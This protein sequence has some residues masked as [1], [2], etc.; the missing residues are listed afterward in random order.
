MGWWR[1]EQEK[2]RKQREES[3]NNPNDLG[4]RSVICINTAVIV[5]LPA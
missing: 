5:Q 2:M 3:M 4:F 1:V